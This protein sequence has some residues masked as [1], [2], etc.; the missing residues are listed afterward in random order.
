MTLQ[1]LGTSNLYDNNATTRHK[2]HYPF[3]LP[4]GWT[5]CR[6]INVCHIFGRIGFRGYTK[7]DLVSHD[8]AIT[9]SPSN[10]INGQMNYQHCTYISWSKYEESPE[11]KIANGDILLVKTGSSFGK[12]AFVS[13]LPQKATINPQFVV[14]KY[15]FCNPRFLTYLLQSGYARKNY[16]DFVLG[17]AIPTFTQVAL[18]DM[19]IPL[20]PMS[21]Q[22]RIVNA[23]D[24]WFN[25]I[26]ELDSETREINSTLNCT[27]TKIIELAISG[28]LVPQDP[29]DEPAEE[30]L[31]RI[32]PS[33]EPADKSHYDLPDSYCVVTLKDI[34]KI[35]SAKPFQIAQKQIQSKGKYPVVSQ[36]ANFIEGYTDSGC[37]YK[38]KTP[39][40]LFGDHTRNV[41]FID[42]DFVVGADGTK[43]L[44]PLV[45]PQYV[46]LSTIYASNT[47]QNRG[48]SRHFSYL[49]KVSIPLPPLN[50]QKRIVAK[51][52]ELFAVI[53]QIQQSLE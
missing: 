35:I 47:I 44:L 24:K 37:A 51:V 16:D 10:I 11:I 20:P 52:D 45:L 9:L 31:R 39:I 46:Y 19:M 27:K 17:T 49:C 26:A 29:A 48:Y 50:E 14:L 36:S 5:W 25:I 3:E 4:K 30:L 1:H 23:L 21:E 53:D 40:I 42:F 15:I 13:D 43:L 7:A 2:P 12:C 33:A 32:K 34:C 6:L 22:Q 28:K 41:K 18:G 8:G 38:I